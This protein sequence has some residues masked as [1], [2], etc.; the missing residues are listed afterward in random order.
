MRSFGGN[1]RISWRE[2]ERERNK[3]LGIEG[4]N[5]PVHEVQGCWTIVEANSGLKEYLGMNYL[6]KKTRGKLSGVVQ[7]KHNKK[8]ENLLG[9]L[10]SFASDCRGFS[11]FM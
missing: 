2:R 6:T 1:I 9:L 8:V 5:V 3:V 11:L 10:P 7:G 4:T